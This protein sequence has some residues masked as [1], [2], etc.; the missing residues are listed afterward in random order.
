MFLQNILFNRFNEVFFRIVT[1]N[2]ISNVF[3]C[4]GDDARNFPFVE[5]KDIKIRKNSSICDVKK[6]STRRRKNT[7]K[8]RKLSLKKL[9]VRHLILLRKILKYSIIM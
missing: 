8:F 9:K 5:N 3:L 7:P 2:N 4:N 6:S 1:E